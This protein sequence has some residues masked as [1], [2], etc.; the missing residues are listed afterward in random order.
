MYP[1][2]GTLSQARAREKSGRS[3]MASVSRERPAGA[4]GRAGPS[5]HPLQ[6]AA[7]IVRGTARLLA[8]IG[9]ASVTEL[10]LPNGR[11]ADIAALSEAGEIWIV[12]VKSGV[13]DFRS[14]VKWPDYREFCDRL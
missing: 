13:E 4:V 5:D 11:R 7:A 3:H 2:T 8:C 14:D 12:E 6:V 9:V 1:P 10:A